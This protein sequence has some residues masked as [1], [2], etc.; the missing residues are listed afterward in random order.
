MHYLLRLLQ[1]LGLLALPA[2][3]AYQFLSLNNTANEI[4]LQQTEKF[5]DSL[6]NLAAA[7]ASRYLVQQNNKD[8]QLL[9]DDLIKDPSVRGV[10][11]FDQLGKVIYQSED[12]LPLPILLNIDSSD[13][14]RA[15]G[16]TPRIGELYDGN[17]KIGYIRI[18]LEQ[19]KLLN[20]IY[21]YQDKSLTS[22]LLLFLLSFLVGTI[23]MALFFRRAEAAYY[24]LVSLT[25][26]LVAK[27]K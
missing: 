6:T 20:L 15:K 10:V 5:S 9:I 13:D 17:T 14:P 2:I 4:R 11:I 19:Q 27:N 12:A 24:R 1:I 26:R 25:S 21:E 23:I 18:S 7:E 16:V 22:I 3:I 8:L